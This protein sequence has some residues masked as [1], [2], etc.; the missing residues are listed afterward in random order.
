M[1]KKCHFVILLTLP[2]S[3]ETPEHMRSPPGENSCRFWLSAIALEKAPGPHKDD[4]IVLVDVL[5]KLVPIFDRL[6]DERL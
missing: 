2:S 1:M 4:D 3:D 5:K 6:T